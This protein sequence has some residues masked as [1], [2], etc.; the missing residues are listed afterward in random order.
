MGATT[1]GWRWVAP[2]GDPGWLLV[3]VLGGLLLA[4]TAAVAVLCV[5]YYR[6]SRRF[7]VVEQAAF[8]GGPLTRRVEAN[9][10]RVDRMLA[11]ARDAL[12][13]AEC[14]RPDLHMIKGGRA[15]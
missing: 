13:E 2:D 3:A 1:S 5:R 14:P 15:S 7:A 11:I 9:E 12:G 10:R 4:V 8:G 6:G